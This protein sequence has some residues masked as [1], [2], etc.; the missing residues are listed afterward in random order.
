MLDNDISINNEDIHQRIYEEGLR[1][2]EF[3]E[4]LKTVILSVYN[5]ARD[6]GFEWNLEY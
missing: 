4:R 1:F 3:A 5:A 2:E 6:C